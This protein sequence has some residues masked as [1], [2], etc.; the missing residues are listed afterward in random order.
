MQIVRYCD[1]SE[2]LGPV[3]SAVAVVSPM[4]FEKSSC[5]LLC[6]GRARRESSPVASV[7]FMAMMAEYD[8]WAMMNGGDKYAAMDGSGAGLLF[9]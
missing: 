7:N 2:A 3:N 5:A 8:S 6:W 9:T 4:Y 1:S